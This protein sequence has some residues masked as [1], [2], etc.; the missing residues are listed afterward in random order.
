MY[1][2]LFI[3]FF[4]VLTLALQACEGDKPRNGS[5]TVRKELTLTNIDV[6]VDVSVPFSSSHFG[7]YVA[8]VDNDVD[9]VSFT[10]GETTD[11]SGVNVLIYRSL[12]AGQSLQSFLQD[13][14]PG[15]TVDMPIEEGGNLVFIRV[16]TNDG[17]QFQEYSYEIN[18]FSSS[19]DLTFLDFPDVSSTSSLR[20]SYVEPSSFDPEVTEYELSAPYALCTIIIRAAV[21]S[22][23]AVLRLNGERILSGTGHY[24]D[25]AVGE[26]EILIEVTPE[27][28]GPSKTYTF[29]INR[30]AGTQEELDANRTLSALN[31]V[32]ADIAGVNH[33]SDQ[34]NCLFRLYD[35]RVNRDQPTVAISATPTVAER[36]VRVG[37][38]VEIDVEG[39]DDPDIEIQDL[40]EIPPEGSVEL[41]V[42]DEGETVYVV[43]LGEDEDGAPLTNYRFVLIRTATNWVS[44]S[45]GA[46]LQAALMNAEPNQEIR[47]SSLD[48]ISAESTLAA[49]GKDGVVFFSDASGTEEEPIILAGINFPT[50]NPAEGSESSVLLELAGQNWLVEGLILSGARNA[51]I[52]NNASENQFRNMIAD[53][54]SG[55]AVIVK[56]GSNNNGFSRLF[57]NRVQGRGLVVGS[58]ADDWASAPDGG[59][60]E[61]IND[62][63]AFGN[64][65]IGSLIDGSIIHLEEG[66]QNTSFIGSLFSHS[67][68]LP[69]SGALIDVQGNDNEFNYSSF[70]FSG[71]VNPASVFRVSDAGKD[72]L[73]EAWGENNRIFENRFDLGGAE[74][75]DVARAEMGVEQV[76]VDQN[77][78]DDGG[79]VTYSGSGINQGFNSPLYQ[80]EWV[81]PN[82]EEGENDVFC[83][84]RGTVSYSD[85]SLIDP[86]EDGTGDIG[87]IIN[88]VCDDEDT[89]QL[90]NISNDGDG[91]ILLL[92]SEDNARYAPRFQG[93]MA[94]TGADA[95]VGFAEELVADDPAHYLRW[96]INAASDGKYFFTNKYAASYVMSM[97]E[98]TSVVNS[99]IN[100]LPV[101]VTTY[102]TD[103]HMMFGALYTGGDYQK[104]SLLPVA[105]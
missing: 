32:P 25:L 103:D 71:Q 52:L 97:S 75:V 22:R 47:V 21:A 91:D 39:Q 55:D 79:E 34:F 24:I 50:L 82:V 9:S 15:Q 18:R 49:S 19:S 53:E 46:E 96:A 102:L 105:Q 56:N 85:I 29:T 13:I 64:I 37:R 51:L 4:S 78:R 69:D 1:K 42:E 40:V 23:G 94:I 59:A 28:N 100:G 8:N 43:S 98:S 45:T 58:D 65:V 61:P 101:R 104:F 16:R 60:D 57:I 38:E 66:A 6:S 95:I 17:E 87:G 31:I 83:L 86:D 93:S 62:S 26:N 80:I 3:V 35:V 11:E 81:K 54:L 63:N 36:T 2:R 44:V 48:V 73:S 27:N 72:W 33:S 70:Q 5:L 10:I 12:V 7:P 67:G 90:W 88:V 68:T 20:V 14:Q 84:A 30:E 41:E 89:A 76:F 74:G 99:I 77:V 92:S